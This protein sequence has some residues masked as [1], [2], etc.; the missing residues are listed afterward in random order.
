MLKFNFKKECISEQ[1]SILKLGIDNI[2]FYRVKFSY[3]YK[4]SY[5]EKHMFKK[6]V[7]IS[8]IENEEF[9]DD[10]LF[11]SEE[12][13]KLYIDVAEKPSECLIDHTITSINSVGRYEIYLKNKILSKNINK[14]IEWFMNFHLN[15]AG[16]RTGFG[17]VGTIKYDITN[18]IDFI[19][20]IN[21]DF[22]GD[23]KEIKTYDIHTLGEDCI[24][25]EELKNLYGERNDIVFKEIERTNE[26]LKFLNKLLK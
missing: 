24:L 22:L 18:F 10:I 14:R 2:V 19:N 6:D 21:K 5:I 1:R 4:V 12:E 8:H 9:I 20:T 16:V 3:K 13:A 17:I 11:N 25:Q 23:F 26:Y 7:E 15:D